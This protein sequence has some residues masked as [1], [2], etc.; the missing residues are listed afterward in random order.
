M[1]ERERTI[2]S[3]PVGM[4][5]AKSLSA[6]YRG[7]QGLVVFDQSGNEIGRTETPDPDW[8]PRIVVERF[9]PEMDDS[10]ALEW[11][12]QHPQR[13]RYAIWLCGI[14]SGQGSEVMSISDSFYFE[15]PRDAVEFRLRFG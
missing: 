14:W 10:P 7:Q 13:S 3:Y 9:Q 12:S 5:T 15:D 8:S 4:P 6:R 1:S 2:A 11:L